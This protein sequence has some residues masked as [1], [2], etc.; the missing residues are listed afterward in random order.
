MMEGS[1]TVQIMTDP[2]PQVHNTAKSQTKTE[3]YFL[4]EGENGGGGGMYR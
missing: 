2:D 1:G 4:N 3:I